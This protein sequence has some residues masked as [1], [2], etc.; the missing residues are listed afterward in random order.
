MYQELKN[1]SIAP[2]NI[3]SYVGV[4]SQLMLHRDVKGLHRE[5][6]SLCEKN[7]GAYIG[8]GIEE[9]KEIESRPLLPAS[10]CTIGE[11][12]LAGTPISKRIVTLLEV[13]IS[14][15]ISIP[16]TSSSSAV[17]EKSQLS[18]LSRAHS[19]VALGKVC[20]IDEPLAKKCVPIFIAEIQNA[21]NEVVRNNILVIMCDLCVKYTAV[22]DKHILRLSECIA[23]ASPLVRRNSIAL[24]TQLLAE[25]YIKWRP[26]LFYRFLTA[27]ADPSPHVS[28]S[29]EFA[30]CILLPKRHSAL[31]FNN[32]IESIF[33]LNNFR[34]PIPAFGSVAQ[35]PREAA[36]FSLEGPGENEAKRKL[37]YKVLLNQLSMEQR[38]KLHGRLHT[39]VLSLF[40]EGTIPL[41]EANNSR[42]VILDVLSILAC[43]EMKLN[44]SAADT[45]ARSTSS[46]ASLSSEITAVEAEAIV[47]GASELRNR[48]FAQVIKRHIS[49]NV[50]PI[51][52]ELKR[53][54]EKCRSPLLKNVML[55]MKEVMRDYKKEVDGRCCRK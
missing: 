45:R 2:A 25:D 54:L 20:L 10:L 3:A 53:A 24:L 11:I 14:T 39:E 23:D 50:V 33:F 15:T 44:A 49:E 21:A 35:S 32:F 52:I 19:F 17:E 30:V 18:P 51:I 46:A 8:A 34:Q 7:L 37:I 36:L 28:K 31:V 4:L 12:A 6:L 48:L 41:S 47:G 22:V 42:C 55:Y 13:L 16:G 26:M 27:L 38:L 43:R 5:L 29:A 9:R 1:F 40:A